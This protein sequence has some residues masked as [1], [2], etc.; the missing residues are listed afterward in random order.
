[1]SQ[2]DD[3]TGLVLSDEDEIAKEATLEREKETEE[4][5]PEEETKP[6]E[7]GHK[8]P[9]IN[10]RRILLIG[11]S[12]ASLLV[13]FS[14]VHPHENKK[15]AQDQAVATELTVPD[16]STTPQV[17]EDPVKPVP[18]SAPARATMP[19]YALSPQPEI[20]RPQT[21]EIAKSAD[22]TALKANASAMI[23]PIQG[24][25]VGQEVQGGV[26][27]TAR[28][29]QNPLAQAASALGLPM[30]QDQYTAS[31]LSA[32]G[33]LAGGGSAGGGSQ[34]DNGMTYQGQ[35]MQDIKQAF[36]SS[37]RKDDATGGF[38]GSDT[39]WNGTIIPG[40]LITGIN[41]DLPGD[42]EA[43]VSENIYDSLTGKE[44]LIPQ[45]SILIAA[46][47]SSV[48]FAQ[49]RVQIAWNTL[50]RPDG[51]QITL[52]NMNGVDEQGYSGT[53]GRM[54]EHLF[55]YVKAAGIISAFTIANGEFNNTIASTTNPSVQNLVAA[56]QNYITQVGAKIIDRTMNIQPTLTVKSGTKINIMLNKNI[57]LPPVEDHP[58]TAVYRRN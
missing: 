55:E 40:V 3:D 30:G 29:G 50:I 22:D 10:K 25:L 42:I 20:Q 15:K 45:G 9:R 46:Y 32:L 17:Y 23:P 51:F 27:S 8:V 12:A 33:G 28:Q 39:V 13:I 21:Q 16:F 35:N 57:S 54:D 26:Y 19:V 49:S 37:G 4:K 38:I 18:A 11:A 53:K 47:N 2:Y 14:I 41:T 1:M 56:N 43:R 52:G 7:N 6:V 48:S 44:L 58:V 31:R 36:Y 24:R 34:P 5:P